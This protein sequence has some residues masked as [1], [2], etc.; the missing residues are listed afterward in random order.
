[1][2]LL[3]SVMRRSQSSTSLLTLSSALTNQLFWFS[4]LL[5]VSTKYRSLSESLHSKWGGIVLLN[6]LS[7]SSS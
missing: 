6:S 2:V 7:S 1:M 3:V 5:I 4:N